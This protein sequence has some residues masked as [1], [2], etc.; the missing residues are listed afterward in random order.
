MQTS[1][2]E[3]R[4]ALN[5]LDQ[6][7]PPTSLALEPERGKDNLVPV[8]DNQLLNEFF[9]A[10]KKYKA[11]TSLSGPDLHKVEMEKGFHRGLNQELRN[12]FTNKKSS[13]PFK[14]LSEIL[15]K[16]DVPYYLRL[17]ILFG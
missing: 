8:Q 12:E 6:T 10:Y 4:D 11:Y 1:H 7:Y 14:R 3:E 9:E 15:V 16:L 2:H 17:Q 5:W 13:D